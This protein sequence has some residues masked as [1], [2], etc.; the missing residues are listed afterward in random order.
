VGEAG[1]DPEFAVPVPLFPLPDAPVPKDLPLGP[2]CDIL[3]A[4]VDVP[5]NVKQG[6]LEELD[7]AARCGL[8]LD[9]VAWASRPR[10]PPGPSLN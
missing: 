1:F 9:A 8:L 3:S 2:L 10:T 4:M 7:V 6:L 5:A